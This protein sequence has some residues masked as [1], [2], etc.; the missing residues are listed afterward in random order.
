M[1]A[2]IMMSLSGLSVIVSMMTTA[3]LKIWQLISLAA[4]NNLG[5]GS[6]L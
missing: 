5:R 1:T 6:V 3:Q 4:G 2:S